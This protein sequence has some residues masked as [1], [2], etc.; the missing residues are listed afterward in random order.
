MFAPRHNLSPAMPTQNIIDLCGPDGVPNSFTVSGFYGGHFHHLTFFSLCFERSQQCF[1]FGI[2]HVSPVPFVLFLCYGIQPFFKVLPNQAADMRTMKSRLF[3]DFR[4]RFSFATH[5]Q[6]LQSFVC[7]LIPVLFPRLFY[8]CVI[9]CTEFV[10]HFHHRSY[11]TTAIC[12]C[13]CFI[14]K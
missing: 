8:L 11:Y 1:F 13:L 3:R 12:A 5:F 2:A 10:L 6:H 7:L 4:L 9:F 14:R